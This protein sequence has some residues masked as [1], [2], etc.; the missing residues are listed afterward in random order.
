M[1]RIRTCWPWSLNEQKVF[2]I[3]NNG[4]Y[5]EEP[6]CTFK[7]VAVSHKFE[8]DYILFAAAMVRSFSNR[9]KS[10]FCGKKICCTPIYSQYTSSLPNCG[11]VQGMPVLLLLKCMHV[12]ILFIVGVSLGLHL[13]TRNMDS[14]IM[15]EI[16]SPNI[17]YKTTKNE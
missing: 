9:E 4:Y 5:A 8:E 6:F 1:C 7:W 17:Q 14:S 13:V 11:I 2:R 15:I 10:S 16:A 12:P 3:S